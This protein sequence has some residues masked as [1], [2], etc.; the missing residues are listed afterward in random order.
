MLMSVQHCCAGDLQASC[1]MLAEHAEVTVNRTDNG[2]KTG[3]V[4]WRGRAGGGKTPNE[5]SNI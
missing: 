4:P 5:Q 1:P 3:F 2:L